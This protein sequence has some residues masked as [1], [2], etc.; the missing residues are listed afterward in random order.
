MNSQKRMLFAIGDRDAGVTN[1]RALQ[2]V[3]SLAEEAY[4]IDVVTCDEELIEK[5]RKEF[6]NK[7][8]IRYACLKQDECFWTMA[9]RDGFAKT[10]IN[11]NH[12][13]EIPGIDL[14]FWKMTGFDDFLWNTS[15]MTYPDI[16]EHYDAIIVPIPSYSE[17]PPNRVDVLYT[18]VIFHAKQNHIPVVGLQ[19]YPIYDVPPIFLKIV[20]H[21]VVKDDMEKEYYQENGVIPE[22][23]TLID[24]VKD[25]YCLSTV[26]DQYRNLAIDD[27]LEVPRDSI[28][29]VVVNHSRNRYQ[30]LDVLE[31]IGEIDVPKSVFFVFLSFSVKE[32]HEQDIFKDLIRPSLEKNVKKYYTVETGALIKSLMLCDAIVATN[33]IVPLSFAHQ[34]GK[35]GIVYNPLM[36]ESSHVKGVLFANNKQALKEALYK[37][38]ERKRNIK[39][40]ADVVSGVVSCH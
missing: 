33:Y 14:K 12:D 22:R 30:L 38:Y 24:D 8:N 4:M 31:A 3:K 21:F 20:D 19:I 35:G 25:N 26:Q 5:C 28:G 37:Q 16:S 10:F 34:Y 15:S 17:G 27:E 2:L 36:T 18:H 1:Y 29:I 13:L 9:Q 7:P 6:D 23:V 32:L 11:L 40:V 39:T